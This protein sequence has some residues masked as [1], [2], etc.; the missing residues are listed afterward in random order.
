MNILIVDDDKTI[1][2]VFK[3]RLEIDNH[4]CM[5]AQSVGEAWLKNRILKFDILL[6]DILLGDLQRGDEFAKEYKKA[7]PWTRIFAVTGDESIGPQLQCVER[8]LRKPVDLDSLLT[9]INSSPQ[10]RPQELSADSFKLD[11]QDAMLIMNLVNK[12]VEHTNIVSTT[13]A[14]ISESIEELSVAVEREE[15]KLTY[16]YEMLKQIDESGVVKKYSS[17]SKFFKDAAGK[18]FWAVVVLIGMF[19]LRGPV[20]TFLTDVLTKK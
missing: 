9:F 12:V 14:L 10:A 6:I 8:V 13:Q 2:E 5:I 4:I 19:I 1:C 17:V 11:I 3:R 20:L 16:I 15:Q 7:C 18:I